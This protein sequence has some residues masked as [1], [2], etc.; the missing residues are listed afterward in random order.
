MNGN[1]NAD[2]LARALI[3]AMFAVAAWAWPSAPAQIPI[4]WNGA[5]QVNGYGPKALGLILNPVV[6]LVGYTLIGLAP[7][8]KPEQFDG[9]T[10]SA[11]SWFRLTYALLMSGVFVVIVAAARGSNPNINYTLPLLA[12]M[13]IAIANLLVRTIRARMGKTAPPGGGVRI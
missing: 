12:L 6:A 9:P 2:W 10:R 7:R 4:H 13:M 11:L 3:V 1:R 5:G 8:F